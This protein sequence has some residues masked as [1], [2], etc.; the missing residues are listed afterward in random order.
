MRNDRYNT[1][2]N[3]KLNLFLIYDGEGDSVKSLV[4]SKTECNRKYLNLL[5]RHK[6]NVI[7]LDF[8]EVACNMY[9][10]FMRFLC[11]TT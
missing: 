1:Q 5:L 6:P 11:S 7:K 9:V 2:C 4:V 8:Y 3:N 10:S